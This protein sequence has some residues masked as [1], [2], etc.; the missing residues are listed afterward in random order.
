MDWPECT[1]TTSARA[2]MGVYIYYRIWIKNFTQVASPIHHLFKKNIPFLWRKKQVEAIDLLK[3]A[4]TSPPALVSLD[5]S[6]D[7]GEIILAVDASLEGWGGVLMQLVK[8]KRHPSRYESGIW[9]SAEKKYDATK[10]ECRGVLKALKKVRYWLY[11]V[12]FVLKTDARVLVAQLNQSD[13]DLLGA[14][15]T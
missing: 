14:L 15:V 10:R 11:G 1:D 13:T 2:F 8:G 7:A 5:Y 12:R 6:K 9:S 4:L 3:L